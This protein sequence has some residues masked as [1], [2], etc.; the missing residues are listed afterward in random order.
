[1][2]KANEKL[3]FVALVPDEPLFSE[4]VNVKDEV[5]EKYNSRAALKSPPHITLYMPFRWHENREDELS[6]VLRDIASETEPFTISLNGFSCFKP[7]VI[8]INPLENEELNKLQK[9]VIIS[10]KRRL[11]L[12]DK[13]FEERPFKPHITIAF[14]DL[15]KPLF[16]KAWN[17]DFKER[18]FSAEFEVKK[19]SLL[20][21]NG[22][23]W[24]VIQNLK[25]KL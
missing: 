13:G 8:Y 17:E 6:G 16:F 11:K 10:F 14:R 2:K 3:Y 23:V 19:I 21:H 12:F 1:M 18:R 20:K 4:I 25:L 22:K 24:E 5:A 7:R 15:K 9:K